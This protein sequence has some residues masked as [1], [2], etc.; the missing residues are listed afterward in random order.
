M[1]PV[2]L[3]YWNGRGPVGSVVR[4]ATSSQ[5][6]HVAVA[7]EWDGLTCYFESYPRSGFRLVPVEG[8]AL[9]D[10]VQETGL[11][12]QPGQIA[13]VM[14]TLSRRRYSVWNGI[15]A[16]IGINRKSEAVEC[17]QAAAI[18]LSILGLLMDPIP[19]PQQVAIEVERKT[20]H[21]VKLTRR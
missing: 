11:D 18:I 4:H 6:D 17:A 14:K 9:P 8:D 12:W 10:G 3:Y 5:W 13:T 1:N 21:P 15:L 16:A 7:V 20:G 19:E 2:R